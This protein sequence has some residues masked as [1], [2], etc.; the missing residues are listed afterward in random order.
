MLF[1]SP[2][3]AAGACSIALGNGA[4]NTEETSIAIGSSA[5][6]NC[7]NAIAIGTQATTDW[8]DAIAIGTQA[9]AYY[10]AI[11]IGGQAC[12][13]GDESIAIGVGSQAQAGYAISLGASRAAGSQ[14]VAIGFGA[15]ACGDDGVS[16]GANAKGFNGPNQ[17]VIGAN[18]VTNCTTIAPPFI[19]MG[20]NT[21]YQC[22]AWNTTTRGSINIGYENIHCAAGVGILIGN[23]NRQTNT[24]Y[25][26]A[27]YNHSI[28][29]GWDNISS[30]T[31]SNIFGTENDVTAGQFHDI[32]GSLN[33][34]TANSSVI[35]GNN[36]CSTGG[37]FSRIYGVSNKVTGGFVAMAFGD[38]VCSSGCYSMGFG[39][40]SNVTHDC[41]VTLGHGMSSV[42]ACYAHLPNLY[43]KA[44]VEAADQA[45]AVTA[46]LTAGQVY[47]TAT[48]DLKIVY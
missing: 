42:A 37:Q 45:A 26:N 41:A 43:L 38:S 11:A 39:A 12:T 27:P 34:S 35:H 32:Y 46:G 16:I 25:N 9:G 5:T 19:A 48:G 14:S 4:C 40:S 33:I 23:C 29:I 31:Y 36:N 30:S 24:S 28:I 44:P 8:N 1:R 47:K 22:N 13:T 10:K 18:T 17:V 6:N 20:K 21:L 15:C 7:I 2:A 3:L